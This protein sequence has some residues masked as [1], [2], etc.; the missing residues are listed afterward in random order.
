MKMIKVP[1]IKK[2]FFAKLGTPTSQAVP[3]KIVPIK[4]LKNI[5]QTSLL[6]NVAAI[7]SEAARN[8]LKNVQQQNDGKKTVKGKIQKNAGEMMSALGV[9]PLA[10]NLKLALQLGILLEPEKPDYNSEEYKSSI[11]LYRPEIIAL[12]KFNPLYD[13]NLIKTEYGNL[14][15]A[16]IETLRKVDVDERNKVNESP[17]QQDAILKNNQK[18]KEELN[19]LNSKIKELAF[20]IQT[21]VTLQNS[22]D[23]SKFNFSPQEFL[24]FEFQNSQA[25]STYDSLKNYV[26]KMEKSLNLNKSLHYS[27]SYKNKNKDKKGDYFGSPPTRSWVVALEEMKQ[28][29]HSHSRKKMNLK[30]NDDGPGYLGFGFLGLP[31]I[32]S[33]DRI[34]AK[35]IIDLGNEFIGET[36]DILDGSNRFYTLQEYISRFN[37]QVDGV[38]TVLYVMLKEIRQRACLKAL[39]QDISLQSRNQKINS[40]ILNSYSTNGLVYKRQ[41]PFTSVKLYDIG[42]FGELGNRNNTIFALEKQKLPGVT[43]GNDYFFKDF[44]AESFFT[45]ILSQEGTTD[46]A[47]I[48]DFTLTLGAVDKLFSE[49]LLNSGILPIDDAKIHDVKFST[50]P[51][52]FLEDI[53]SKLL[54]TQGRFL[55]TKKIGES[56]S[57]KGYVG[58]GNHDLDVLML[59]GLASGN[60]ISKSKM[61][62]RDLILKTL[63]WN[64]GTYRLQI[65]DRTPEKN[66][67]ILKNAL[68]SYVLKRLSGQKGADEA[69]K[70]IAFR[71]YFVLTNIA[72]VVGAG[73]ITN[74]DYVSG[75]AAILVSALEGL[76]GGP[77]GSIAAAVYTAVQNADPASLHFGVPLQEG[78]QQSVLISSDPDNGFSDNERQIIGP[79]TTGAPEPRNVAASDEYIKWGMWSIQSQPDSAEDPSSTAEPFAIQDIITTLQSST[80][81]D[82]IVELMRPVVESDLGEDFS[83][84]Y[85][86]IICNLIGGLAP[87][88]DIRVYIDDY[89][90]EDDAGHAG[91]AFKTDNEIRSALVFFTH[92]YRHESVAQEVAATYKQQISNNLIE[93]TNSLISLS[94]S[95]LNVVSS[96]LNTFKE[97]NN[98]LH[99]FKK[100]IAQYFAAYL[101]NDPKKFALMFTEQQLSL[102]INSFQD[103]FNSYN[104]FTEQNENDTPTDQ[105]FSN[106]LDSL[107]Y[108]TKIVQ[109][110]RRFFKDKDYTLSKGY[111]K[112]ILTVGIPQGLL[113]DLFNKSVAKSIN[114]GEINLSKVND[115]FKILVYKIDLLNDDLVYLPQEFLFEMSRFV[116]KDYSKINPTARLSSD[117]EDSLF[118]F[119]STRNFSIYGSKSNSLFEEIKPKSK[120]N[121]VFSSAEYSKFL[122]KDEMSSILKNHITS[123][124][125]ENYLQI[126]S[127]MKLNENSFILSEANEVESLYQDLV[128]AK[129]GN[130]GEISFGEKLSNNLLA[131]PSIQLKKLLH[132]K[133]FDRVF[134]IIFDPDSF[135][136]DENKTYPSIINKM[137]Q[138]RIIKKVTYQG[139][140]YYV[141]ND[142]SFKDPALNSYFV[143]I[144]TFN[145]PVDIVDSNTTKPISNVGGVKGDKNGSAKG[146]TWLKK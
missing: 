6:Q 5:T 101:N 132:P 29:I 19:A 76:I 45:Q 39:N 126:L 106:R 43:N 3:S 67:S 64:A 87:I 22:I 48:D 62:S 59:F 52:T 31:D 145:T 122:N 36:E 69:I 114:T 125:L 131:S 128:G 12:T 96:F 140:T 95:T 10:E 63:S 142:R 25:F 28:M 78:E 80:F 26:S 118:R 108:S 116:I 81:I 11:T 42:Y 58:A 74:D 54:D 61:K 141:D 105:L 14:F 113:K 100:D 97:I 94:F 127:G 129:V 115:I 60:S 98:K 16:L 117:F 15:E 110:T 35:K 72:D 2:D 65:E 77:L 92:F 27:L 123:F 55:L 107:P 135:I 53:C 121:E 86:D 41:D 70:S 88:K 57:G 134:N 103:F 109:A 89:H 9:V 20:F 84:A 46:K 18:L 71:I 13:D 51:V 133:V 93:E 82:E 136:V 85:F 73:L 47:R 17:S 138:K 91:G 4:S 56:P 32:I 146:P 130:K 23:L 50:N 99:T 38:S 104:V 119:F 143:N 124:I 137:E 37:E 83:L 24:S 30:M 112:Q 33:N 1:K 75:A 68:Y 7:S 34:T 66:I 44:G 79:T 49:Y 102:I 90:M 8:V 120:V 139:K 111:N 144:E 21:F 40:L